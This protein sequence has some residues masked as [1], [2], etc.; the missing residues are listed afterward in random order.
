MLSL[1]FQGIPEQIAVVTLAVVLARS[2]LILYKIVL[3]GTVLALTAFIL[4]LFPITFG[5]HT[6]I[7]MGLLFLSLAYIYKASLLTSI[8]ATLITYILLI[9]VEYVFF[10]LFTKLLNI[11]FEKVLTELPLRIILGLPQVFVIFIIAFMILHVRT[12][13]EII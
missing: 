2:P 6:I 12:R 11:P 8:R 7:L 5:I 10:N 9:I 1:V 3:N 4:R 13:R